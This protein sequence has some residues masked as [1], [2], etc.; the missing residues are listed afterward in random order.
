MSKR[1]TGYYTKEVAAL[2]YDLHNSDMIDF[3]QISDETVEKLYSENLLV[4]LERL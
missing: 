4:Y 3:G 1:K 2:T